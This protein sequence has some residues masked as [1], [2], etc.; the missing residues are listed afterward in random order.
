MNERI[1]GKRKLDEFK[2]QVPTNPS[3]PDPD[4]NVYRI[5]QV[6]LDH[7]SNSARIEIIRETR[8]ISAF[9]AHVNQLRHASHS[10]VRSRIHSMLSLPM[11][12]I[13]EG[14]IPP[15][16]I[17]TGSMEYHEYTLAEILRDY[18]DNGLFHVSAENLYNIFSS[19]TNFPYFVSVSIH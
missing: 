13:P 6:I 15:Q 7:A 5:H 18:R 14:G 17:Y 9:V 3:N 8:D 16:I 10:R 1:T 4:G 2:N 12:G 19:R 11:E